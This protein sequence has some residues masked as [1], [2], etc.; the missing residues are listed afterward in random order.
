MQYEDLIFKDGDTLFHSEDDSTH[1]FYISKGNVDLY[2]AG[3]K[4]YTAGIGEFLGQS[5]V[6]SGKK[7]GLTA[8]AIGTI[9]VQKIEKNEFISLVQDDPVVAANVVK[10]MSSQI[11]N[12]KKVKTLKP[13]SNDLT[14]DINK[15]VDGFNY[16]KPTAYRT[17]HA[18][19]RELIL[20]SDYDSKSLVAANPSLVTM[21]P[22]KKSFVSFLSSFITGMGSALIDENPITIIVPKIEG[23]YNNIY[24]NWIISVME[25]LAKIKFISP[26]EVL[27]LEDEMESFRKSYAMITKHNADLAIWGG[28]DEDGRLLT[29]KFSSSIPSVDFMA[30]A[31]KNTLYIPIQGG[32]GLYSLLRAVALASINPKDEEHQEV[33]QD[34]LPIAIAEAEGNF[35]T[36]PSMTNDERISNMVCLGNSAYTYA[37][38]GGRDDFYRKA[39]E[40]YKQSLNQIS[41]T[42][43]KNYFIVQTQLGQ[44]NKSISEKTGTFASIDEAINNFSSALEKISKETNPMVWAETSFNLAG[45]YQQK[46]TIDGSE[47]D[48]A[49]AITN[50][51]STLDVFTFDAYPIKW[52]EVMNSIGKSLQVFGEINKDFDALKRAVKMYRQSLMVRSKDMY[53]LL[54]A[55]TQNNLGSVQFLLARHLK[56][57][58]TLAKSIESFTMAKDVYSESGAIRM[59]T[60]VEKN[61]SRAI[62]FRSELR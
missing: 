19:G 27:G 39:N 58:D 59:Q 6:I 47:E 45:S 8:K 9:R 23:D 60:I 22:A 44:I 29:L 17:A 53:P 62:S 54:W 26:K 57:K 61:L 36:A 33:L 50:Y 56:D 51:Q 14:A 25:P 43:D 7:Y 52:A 1:A 3:K 24:H 20:T 42:D 30:N 21:S 11:Y 48:F 37:Q 49:K 34:L 32:D 41:P 4:I 12:N 31:P 28:V 55:H 40:I 38:S 35:I 2:R 13:Q 16:H 10:N 18:P 46:A 5:G 15:L